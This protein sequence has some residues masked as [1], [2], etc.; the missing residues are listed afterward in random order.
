MKPTVV[1]D[2]NKSR[3][4]GD[5]NRMSINPSLSLSGAFQSSS[6]PDWDSIQTFKG[7]FAELET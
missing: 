5:F 1:C 3:R 2:F 4:N 7:V 6:N